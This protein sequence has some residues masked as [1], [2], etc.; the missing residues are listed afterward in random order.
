MKRIITMMLIAGMVLSLFVVNASAAGAQYFYQDFENVSS[1]DDKS[2]FSSGTTNSDLLMREVIDDPYLEGNKALKCVVRKSNAVLDSHM[3]AAG[4][5]DGECV[6][7]FDYI[8][9]STTGDLSA[10]ASLNYVMIELSKGGSSGNRPRIG[11]TMM[12]Y[13]DGFRL[14]PENDVWYSFVAHVNSDFS[15]LALYRK[16]RDSDEPYTFVRNQARGNLTGQAIGDFRIYGG[17]VDYMIDNIS[18]CQGGVGTNGRFEMDGEKITELSQVTSGTLTAMTDFF[19]G[20][21]QTSVVDGQTIITGDG[22]VF[23]F[24]VVY[25]ASGKMI[26]CVTSDGITVG[27][28]KQTIS[29]DIDTSGFYDKLD[30]GYIGYYMWKDFITAEPLMDAVELY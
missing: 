13:K 21:I 5:I 4:V 30:G 25:D 23:P 16:E 24:V 6:F 18:L 3:N 8:Q 10:N 17:P 20:D 9:L 1:S 7:A 12:N 14:T 19:N 15:S 2:G 29:L 26:D 11:L 22:E 28:G 27:A